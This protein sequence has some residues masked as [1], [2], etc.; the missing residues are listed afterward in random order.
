[1]DSSKVVCS[2]STVQAHPGQDVVLSCRVEPPFDLTHETLEWKHGKEDVHRYPSLWDYLDHQD[3]RFFNRTSLITEYLKD[4][5]ASLTL[6]NFTNQDE[7]NY[8]FCLPE[9]LS[10]SDVT[11]TE[12]SSKVVCS[13]STVQ[14]HPGQDVVLSCRVEPPFDLT[15]E[16]LEWKH[17]KEDVHRYPSLWDYLDH[18]DSRFFNRTSLITEYLKDGIASL[19]LTNFTNQDEGNYS[20]C[21]PELLSC[22]DVTLTENS[23]KVVCSPSTVQAHPGQDVVLSCRVEPPFDLTRETLEWKHGTTG[24]MHVYRSGRDNYDEQDERFKNRTILNHQNLKDGNVSLTLTNFTMKDEGNYTFCLRTQTPFMCSDV[25]L[26]KIPQMDNET[27][28]HPGSAVSFGVIP[29]IAVGVLGGVLGVL[30]VAV[31]VRI[32]AFRYLRRFC[33]NHSEEEEEE[34]AVIGTKL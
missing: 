29:A 10:C 12:N 20:F 18:Q 11:L 16:T 9:L 33:F 6:T 23:S 24:F 1:M 13:P 34:P 31:V 3:S 32:L 17:G 30:G 15:H 25:T 19:T 8:S 2:P 5:I 26:T 22:S 27:H 14:A 7:G 28:N 4:G 21:L